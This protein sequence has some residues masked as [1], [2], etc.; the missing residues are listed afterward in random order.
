MTDFKDHPVSLGE[1]KSDRTGDGSQWT[2]RDVLV[3]MLRDIDSGVARPDVLVV[4][5]SEPP[6]ADAQ[7]ARKERRGHFLQ[8]TND[9]LLSLGL[10][11][12]TIFKMQD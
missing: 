8:S 1:I 2:P 9:G 12:S 5:W 3:K 6:P 10:M 11:Q 7:D 4:A